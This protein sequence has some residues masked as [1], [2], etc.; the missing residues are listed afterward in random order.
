MVLHDLTERHAQLVDEALP[1]EAAL[2]ELQ[3]H[4]LHIWNQTTVAAPSFATTESA[5]TQ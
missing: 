1:D 5:S 2:L 3:H 4:L